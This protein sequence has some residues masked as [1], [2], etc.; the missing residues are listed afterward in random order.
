M[1]GASGFYLRQGDPSVINDK[2]LLVDNVTYHSNWQ[3]VVFVGDGTTL[4]IY[5]D[6]QLIGS[7]NEYYCRYYNIP[8]CV[9]LDQGFTMTNRAFYGLICEAAVWN[10]ALTTEEIN[11]LYNNGNGK[12][13]T[14]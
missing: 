3:H 14:V 13:I 12:Q 6:N 2:A 1:F 5:F 9:G 10:R 4:Y 8:L 11:Y 7:S